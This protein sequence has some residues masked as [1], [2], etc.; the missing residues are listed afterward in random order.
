MSTGLS[1]SRLRPYVWRGKKYLVLAVAASLLSSLA[2]SLTPLVAKEAVDAVVS[3]NLQGLL[4][5]VVAIVV[6]ACVRGAFSF[7][8]RVNARRLAEMV[9]LDL[10]VDVYRKLRE[11]PL[12]YLYE[13]GAG[14][15]V[16]RVTGDVEE[17]KRVFMF[18]LSALSSNVFILILALAAMVSINPLLAAFSLSILLPLVVV[19]RVFVKK[20]RARFREAREEYGRMSSTL[21]EALVGIETLKALGAERFAEG[22]FARHNSSYRDR[23]VEVGRLRAIVWPTLTALTNLALLVVYWLGGLGI[24]EETVSVGDLIA[25]AMYVSMISWPISSLGLFVVV[26]ETAR[27]AASRVFEILDAEVKVKEAP[28]AKPLNIER[29]EVVFE[30]V[31]FSYDGKTWVLRGLNLKVKPGEFVAIT[32]PP[33]SGKSTLALLLLRF[34]DPQRGRI[35]IDGVDIR[36]VTLDSLRRQVVVVHQD[37]YLFPDTI[38]NNIAYAKPDASPEEVV[39]AAKL[40]R[41]HD[42]VSSLPEGYDTPVGERG[43]TLSGGQRQ[44]MALARALLAN[45]RIILLDDTTSEVDAETEKAIWDALTRFF[46]GKTLI[47]IT[48]RPSTMALADRIVVIEDGRV[49]EERL[50]G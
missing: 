2:N 12:T 41:I 3:R 23:M 37:I 35:L 36:K 28:D 24:V 4:L 26:A 46:K 21:R 34:F 29:G 42:F 5:P 11:L 17:I 25:L 38:R 48:Q 40:A 32:G 6:L 14:R 16:A 39:K 31:W 19:L 50:V 30:D 22:R 33:G 7:V 15:L 8:Q 43:V 27:V 13:E 1:L 47:V 49:V 18:G 20:I 45:P 9:S 10:R 44:R